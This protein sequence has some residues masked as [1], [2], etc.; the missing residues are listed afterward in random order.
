VFGWDDRIRFVRSLPCAGWNLDG[1][2]P[3]LFYLVDNA[4]DLL[5]LWP[6]AVASPCVGGCGG[7]D[8]DK[9]SERGI[10]TTISNR[11][12]TK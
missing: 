3:M 1:H 12:I 4:K 8:G 10:L 2:A 7:D 11:P 5:S 9:E 6:L